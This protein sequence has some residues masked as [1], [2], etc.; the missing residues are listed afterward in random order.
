ME[1]SASP[2]E[3]F[4]RRLGLN[5]N[6]IEALDADRVSVYKWQRAWLHQGQESVS[7]RLLPSTRHLTGI[8]IC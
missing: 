3:V 4:A 1:A 2:G 8:S 5:S 7:I 6:L